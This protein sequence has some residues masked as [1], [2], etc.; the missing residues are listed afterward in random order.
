[1]SHTWPAQPTMSHMTYLKCESCTCNRARPPRQRNKLYK[2]GHN[3]SCHTHEWI[4]SHA[5]ISSTESCVT[6]MTSR[7][8]SRDTYEMSHSVSHVPAMERGHQVDARACTRTWRDVLHEDVTRTWFVMSH[9]THMSERH[10]VICHT[11]D[12]SQWLTS[13]IWNESRPTWI[14]HVTYEWIMS[15]MNEWRHVWMSHVTYEWVTSHMNESCHTW[16]SQVTHTWICQITCEWVTSHMNE[17]RHVWMS[18]VTYEWVMSHMND[19]CHTY[20]RYT[21]GMEWVKMEEM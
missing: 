9:V 18:H 19:S 14:S 2:R 16:M 7:N 4:M 13:H 10:R 12:Q 8:E 3:E 20:E 17:S 21:Y 5:W 6:H 1:M 11:H 15:R